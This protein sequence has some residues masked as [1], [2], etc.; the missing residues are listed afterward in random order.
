MPNRPRRAT[1]P[2][3]GSPEEVWGFLA[4]VEHQLAERRR[5][6]TPE[7]EW[8]A[9]VRRARDSAEAG[10][11]LY[12]ERVLDEVDRHLGETEREEQ[13]RE[14]PRGLVDYV[15][16]GDAGTPTP[17]EE[18]SLANRLVLAGRLLELRRS[19]GFETSPWSAQLL[20]AETAYRAGDRKAAKNL[21]DGVIGGL[22]RLDEKRP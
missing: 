14:F 6:G 9:Q 8:E 4:G 18:D 10:D 19:E 12:A 20:E 1:G 11:W 5:A 7:P 3:S 17:E 16:V 13:L 22:E 15:P 21:V 2:R